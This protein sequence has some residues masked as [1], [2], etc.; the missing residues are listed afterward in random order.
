MNPNEHIS[1]EELAALYEKA[2]Q[3]ESQQLE[4]KLDRDVTLT[5]TGPVS[6]GKTSAIKTL[7]GIDFGQISPMPGSTTE[8]KA[9]RLP[10]HERVW[11]LD[12]PGLHDTQSALSDSARKAFERTDVFLYFINA[13]G[14]VTE[15]VQK[16]YQSIR[17]LGKPV[18]AALNKVDLVRTPA[19]GAMAFLQEFAE[20]ARLRL[21]APAE[22]FL[23]C[24]LDP[25][26]RLSPS[27]IHLRPLLRW[28]T[29][30]LE[31][32]GK[33]LPFARALAPQNKEEL[34][35]LWILGAAAAAFGVGALPLAGA[36]LPALVAL[37]TALGLR[38]AG[39]YNVPMDFKQAASLAT[40]VLM[41]SAGKLAFRLI[42]EG[43]SQIPTGVTQ[44]VAG[45]VA[46]A[47]T[48]LY[49]YTILFACKAFQESG[50]LV[51]NPKAQAAQEAMRR[52][53][54]DALGDK[55][56]AGLWPQI[57]KAISRV[58]G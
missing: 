45:A 27:P 42:L 13:E 51:L 35:S 14:S 23:F 47:T 18:L 54:R 36:D 12:T 4:G 38:I 55:V 44:V 5:F 17:A 11:I 19:E 48:L 53:L 50:S 33:D 7:F 41:G 10:G 28:I 37:Q 58:L 2:W 1:T 24:A 29:T 34:A 39:M 30:R 20:H 26:P 52:A 3:E 22:D 49:G 43:M 9:A 40:A 56:P 57:E 46:A 21:G 16:Y 25:D 32:V 15:P 8:V 6:S 31:E